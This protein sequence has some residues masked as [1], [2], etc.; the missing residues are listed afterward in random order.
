[1][2]VQQA[3]LEAGSVSSA[4]LQL[5]LMGLVSQAPGMRYRRLITEI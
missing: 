2:I 4:L 3:A 5:E 1:I